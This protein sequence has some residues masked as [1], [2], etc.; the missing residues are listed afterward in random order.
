MKLLNCKN[1]FPIL[2]HDSV[3]PELEGALKMCQPHLEESICQLPHLIHI[4]DQVLMITFPFRH[5]RM[6]MFVFQQEDLLCP[7]LWS[8]AK[9]WTWERLYTRASSHL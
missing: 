6:M 1:K 4:F 5:T 7:Q 3:F 2:L 9:K 8:L